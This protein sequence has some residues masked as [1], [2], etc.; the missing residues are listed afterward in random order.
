[1]TYVSAREYYIT[2][3]SQVPY[4]LTTTTHKCSLYL[5]LNYRVHKISGMHNNCYLYSN[6]I[7]IATV[8]PK[9][10]MITL[11]LKLPKL[12]FVIAARSTFKAELTILKQSIGLK[13]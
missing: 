9:A 2:I 7:S 10:V 4:G 11:S 5:A 12:K 1:M 6:S 8:S 3:V 13:H